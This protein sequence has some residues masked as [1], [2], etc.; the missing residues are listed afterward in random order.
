MTLYE[1]LNGD[2]EEQP[3]TVTLVGLLSGDSRVP[4]TPAEQCI[5]ETLEIQRMFL[6]QIDDRIKALEGRLNKSTKH[7]EPA[8][9]HATLVRRAT[10]TTN[11][12]KTVRRME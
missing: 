7:S 12:K 3:D 9:R 8:D 5:I 11:S 6:I 10:G 4:I 1:I 2:D